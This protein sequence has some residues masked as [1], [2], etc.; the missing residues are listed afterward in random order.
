MAESMLKNLQTIIAETP[1]PKK[2]T[3]D[4]SLKPNIE[5]EDPIQD[6][7]DDDDNTNVAIAPKIRVFSKP[8]IRYH[9]YGRQSI[10]RYLEN[11]TQEK[12][13]DPFF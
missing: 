6:D 4:W 5:E 7:D 9:A 2:I 10:S 11:H 12:G 3:I 1:P 13:Y 8:Q